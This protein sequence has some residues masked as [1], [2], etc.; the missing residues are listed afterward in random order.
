MRRVREDLSALLGSLGRPA[1]STF[2]CWGCAAL[3]YP[4]ATKGGYAGAVGASIV[5]SLS[6]LFLAYLLGSGAL[7]FFLDA[8]LSCLPGSQRLERRAY[9]V[10]TALLLPTIVLIVAALAGNPVWPAWI[11]PVLALAITLA[12]MLG[13]RRPISAGGL[14]LLVVLAA[15]WT[16]SAR[17]GYERGRSWHFALLGAAIVILAGAVPQ[18]AAVNW[19][20]VMKRG[21]RR[22]SFVE[23]LRAIRIRI[24]PTGAL[25]H[26]SASRRHGSWE[27]QPAVRI[28]RICLGGMFVPVARQVIIGTIL[29]VLFMVAAIGLPWLGVGG[30]RW[31]VGALALTAAGLVSAGFLTQISKLTREEMA[32]L[33]LLPGLGAPSAQSLAL[34][35]AVLTPP[36]LWLGA[37]LLFGSADLLLNGEP[38]SSVGVLALGL[39]ILWLSYAVFALQRLA[40]LPAK[41]QSFISE[42][43]L[44]YVVVYAS[45]TYYWVYAAHPQF[46]LWFWFWIIPAMWSIGVASAIGYSLRRLATAPHPFIS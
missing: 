41:R 1:I 31:L 32:E 19:R 12:G 9:I 42:F 21:H 11:P 34:C 23:R 36:V 45:G 15:Y 6:V 10:A 28:V 8:K 17:G 16:A 26:A 7:A 20:R 40:T 39:F 14:L 37:L 18:L 25:R 3:A 46:R 5:F 38:P 2:V 22:P 29:L 27:R 4:L 13:P 30:R 33:A 35:R 43:L 24:E 44:L